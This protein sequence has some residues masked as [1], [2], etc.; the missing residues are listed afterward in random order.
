MKYF[1][2]YIFGTIL[3]ITTYCGHSQNFYESYMPV[4]YETT[5]SG[6]ISVHF[7]NNNF[8]KNNEYFGP[9]TEGITYIGSILQPEVS[10][11]LSNKFS[12]SAG[13]YFRY[14]YGQEG[15]EQSLP[16]IRASYKFASFTQLL[17]GQIQGQLE[18]GFIEPIYNTDNYFT[19]NPEYGLQFLMDRRK[20]HADMYMD[21]E[22]FILPGETNQEAITGG[23]VAA[24]SLNDMAEKR[25]LSTHVQS[26]FTHIGGQVNNSDIPMQQ[27][28]NIAA[29]IKYSFAPG[30]KA[31]DRLTL[32]SF[33]IQA[34]EISQTNTI[35][36]E[37]GFALHNTIILE[38]KWGKL[39]TGWFHG[40]Y[41]FAPKGDYLFQSVSQF[42]SWYVGEKRDLITSKV[43]LSHDIVKGVNFG[44]RIESYY[45]LQR[46]T[47]DF[48]FGLNISVN[49]K[50]FEKNLRAGKD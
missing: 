3:A 1:I 38:N 48:S 49:A 40:E 46:S 15:F 20:F 4:N 14:F 5:D 36:F 16:V 47:N 17:V 12:L 22:K 10:W 25:G 50:V 42:N 34:L 9:Y 8:I 21:W 43:L 13:W 33:Y 45:D 11:S 2:R 31:L 28:A 32:S 7:Y 29:G 26:I 30:S 18:H 35:P 19:Q 24:Y 41:Y 37:S 39:S 23:L 27:R 6:T 44:F